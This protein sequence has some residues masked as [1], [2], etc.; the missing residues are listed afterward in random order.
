MSGA[1]APWMKGKMEVPMFVICPYCGA[2][3]DPGEKCDCQNR[4][5]EQKRS[6][7]EKEER[8]ATDVR[9]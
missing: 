3:L 7:A 5:E 2:H 8:Q 4:D 6:E 9:G 1:Q